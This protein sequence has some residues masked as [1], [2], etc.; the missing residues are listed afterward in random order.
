MPDAAPT[1]APD[2]LPDDARAV[3]AALGGPGDP[4]HAEAF[5]VLSALLADIRQMGRTIDRDGL[6]VTGSCDNVR[7]HPLLS[8]R[9]TAV[10]AALKLL[11]LFGLV[12][13]AGGGDDDPLAGV[14]G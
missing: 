6:T 1:A 5:G 8:A 3:W 10:S 11:P 9:A 4:R 14:F 2:H 13:D 7:P 12:P